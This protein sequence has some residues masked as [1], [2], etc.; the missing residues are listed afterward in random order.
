MS[1]ARAGSSRLVLLVEVEVLA[2]QRQTQFA[3]EP[4]GSVP[5]PARIGRG[6]PVAFAVQHG[7][8]QLGVVRPGPHVEVVAADRCPHVVDDAQLGVDVD[9]PALQVLDVEH[10]DPVPPASRTMASASACPNIADS[11]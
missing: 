5:E 4:A 9:G 8:G 1:A 7:G 11:L 10:L 6:T 2:H 3:S